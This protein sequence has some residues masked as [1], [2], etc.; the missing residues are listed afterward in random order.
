MLRC[1]VAPRQ[2]FHDDQEGNTCQRRLR[3]HQHIPGER[4]H[5]R[6]SQRTTEERRSGYAERASQR[7]DSCGM[8]NSIDNSQRPWLPIVAHVDTIEHTGPRLPWLT[9][10]FCDQRAADT[11]RPLCHPMRPS[12]G[13]RS[14]SHNENLET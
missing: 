7:R 6:P 1:D 13:N 11:A 4:T 8:P 12:A 9:S 5:W 10:R 14:S 3:Y 2:E